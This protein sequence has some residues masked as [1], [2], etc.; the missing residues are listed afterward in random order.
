MGRPYFC[1]QCNR[2]TKLCKS[3]STHQRGHIPETFVGAAQRLD[4]AEE[5]ASTWAYDSANKGSLGSSTLLTSELTL[6][7]GEDTIKVN[8]LWDMGSESSFFSP[9]LL[10]FGTDQRNT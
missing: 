7:N 9:A 6:L 5:Q 1:L 10:P 8:C 2:N 3:P 4:Y